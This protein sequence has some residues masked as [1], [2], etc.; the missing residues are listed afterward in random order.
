MHHHAE[1]LISSLSKDIE[2]QIGKILAPFSLYRNYESGWW[3]WWVMG[4]RYTGVKVKEYNPKNIPEN[5]EKCWLCHGTGFRTDY[6]GLKSRMLNPSYT[7]NVCGEYDPETKTWANGKM[8][9]GMKLKHP[10]DWVNCPAC[11]LPVDSI[12]S[13]LKCY[14]LI[15]GDKILHKEIWTGGAW[16]DTDFDGSVKKALEENEITEGYLVTVDYHS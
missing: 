1:I 12:P 6:I 2:A 13:D 15:L 8:G 4:G 16:V 14:T 7:C 3:D 9:A 5:Y 10:P 11:I